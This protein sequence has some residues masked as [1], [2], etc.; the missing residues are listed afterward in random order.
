MHVV[1]VP[2]FGPPEVLEYIE[3]PDQEPAAGEVRA[4]VKTVGVNFADITAR[5][6]LYPDSGKPPFVTGYEFSGIVDRVGEG[7]EGVKEGDA[8]IGMKNFGCYADSVVTS[9]GLT[10]PSLL[11]TSPPGTRWSTWATFIRASVS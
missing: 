10:R 9:A 7:V 1:R 11:P 2:K 8:I 5:M 4:A 3:Q 6:G